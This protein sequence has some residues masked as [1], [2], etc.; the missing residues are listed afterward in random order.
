MKVGDLVEYKPEKQV[1]LGRIGVVMEAWH[2]S[3]VTQYLCHWSVPSTVDG[4]SEWYVQ[5]QNIQL[6]VGGDK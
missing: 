6:C 2:L 4:K 3:G 1:G 5:S